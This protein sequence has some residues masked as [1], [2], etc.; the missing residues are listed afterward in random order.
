MQSS[1]RM[2]HYQLAIDSRPQSDIMLLTLC[3]ALIMI[4]Y[5]LAIP[6]M[7]NQKPVTFQD[8]SYDLYALYYTLSGEKIK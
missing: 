8:T 2:P 6:L 5:H 4:H 7:V 3:A 1:Y